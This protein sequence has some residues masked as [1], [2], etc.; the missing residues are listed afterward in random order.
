[1]LYNNIETELFLASNT[2]LD[3]VNYE[4]NNGEELKQIVEDQLK[5]VY[6]LGTLK[7]QLTERQKA[8]I[9]RALSSEK[10]SAYYGVMSESS[11]KRIKE[12][13]ELLPLFEE[14]KI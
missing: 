14:S 5:V 1:M 3:A 12:I 6:E 9:W 2:I 4:E 10:A 13:D 11:Y 7:N 8:I